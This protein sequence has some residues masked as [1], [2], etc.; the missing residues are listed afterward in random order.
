MIKPGALIPWRAS[1][2]YL[3]VIARF[4]RKGY[5]LVGIKVVVPSQ[6]L[7]AK[8]YAEHD[9]KP[10]F[11]KLVNF[12]SSGP[13]VAMV[14]EGKQA[15]KYGRTMIGATNPLAS[16]PGTIRGDFGIDVGRNIIHGSDSVE[17]AQRE[18]ALWFKAEELADYT[19]ST[20]AWVYE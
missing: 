14:W 4:E 19:P 7:A 16:A 1:W 9:G 6:A 13:V 20:A 10:F 5:K 8:H 2:S 15:V 11:P 12:L 3:E 18:I 17:S